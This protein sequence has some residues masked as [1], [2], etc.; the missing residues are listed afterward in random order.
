MEKMQNP[1]ERHIRVGRYLKD[2]VYAANDGVVTTF[3]VVAATV[4]GALS[5]AT[6]LIVG[7]ANLFADGFSMATGNFLGTRS[8]QEFYKKEEAEEWEEVRARPEEERAEVREIL[9]A[10]GYAGQ[11]LDDLLRL[12]TSRGQFWVDFM[13]REELQMYAPKGESALRSATVTFLSF[14]AAGSIPLI[15]YLLFRGEASFVLVCAATA[16]TLFIIGALRAYFSRQSWFLLGCEM[17]AA[18]G[19]AAIIAYG[20]GA[21]IRA[22]V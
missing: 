9:A 14:I 15:P 17:L 8:E 22:L 6:I 16:V 2:V 19:S 3:A 20:V 21:A 10:K 4:G 13:M 7:I 12:M 1:H 18:G 11:E 5:P